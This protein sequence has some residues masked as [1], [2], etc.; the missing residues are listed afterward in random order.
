M[1]PASQIKVLVDMGFVVV[2]PE[3]RLCPQ[4]SLYDGPI[5]DTKDCFL[6]AKQELPGLLGKEGVSVDP[7]SVVAIGYSCGGNLVLHLVCPRAGSCLPFR[8]HMLTFLGRP[9]R[10]TFRDLELLSDNLL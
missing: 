9:P 10:S 5:E 2:T 7:T 6:W 1:I 4:V 8:F 3:Y